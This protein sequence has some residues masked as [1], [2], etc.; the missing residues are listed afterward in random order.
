MR[1]F[2]HCHPAGDDPGELL[3]PDRQVS[4]PW[5]RP[6]HGPCDKC[7]GDGTAVYECF[8]CME[9]GSDP[10]CPVCQGR[11]RFDQTCPTCLGSGEIDRTRRHGIAVFPSREGLYRYLAWKEAELD[12]RVVVELAGTLSDDCDLDAD[13]GA[14]LIFPDRVVSVEPLDPEVVRA[15]QSRTG[16]EEGAG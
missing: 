9:A 1:T 6:E 10:G 16:V 11:V 13:H 12:G 7:G 2:F 8:S 5:G 3:D 4:E 15:I 14:L